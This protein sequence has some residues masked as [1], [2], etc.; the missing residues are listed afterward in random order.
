[1]LTNNDQIERRLVRLERAFSLYCVLQDE[2]TRK[3]IRPELLLNYQKEM[4]Q[5][6]EEIS[7]DVMEFYTDDQRNQ[8]KTGK[9]L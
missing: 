5:V 9:V 1:M 8:K 2:N 3:K 4:T 7:A 6:I